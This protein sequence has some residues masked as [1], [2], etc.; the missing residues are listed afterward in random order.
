MVNTMPETNGFVGR[1][2]LRADL[3]ETETRLAKA[4]GEVA[5]RLDRAGQASRQNVTFVIGTLVTL[6]GMAAGLVWLSQE[7]AIEPVRV[8]MD[9]LKDAQRELDRTLQIEDKA[10]LEK[11]L[12]RIIPLEGEHGFQRQRIIDLEKAVTR[13]ETIEECRRLPQGCR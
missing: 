10:V 6:L 4:I 11:A 8:R 1:A 3:R 7:G 12:G 13:L 5:A 2:E 9:A